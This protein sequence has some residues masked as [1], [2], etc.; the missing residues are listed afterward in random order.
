MS[1]EQ[2][3][4]AYSILNNSHA[5]EWT[6][7]GFGMIRTY[8]DTDKR[9]R[10][11]VW[12]DRLRVP[13]VTTIHDHPWGFASTIICGELHNQIYSVWHDYPPSHEFT[14]IMTGED[15][16][17]LRT[18]EQNQVYLWPSAREIKSKG[19]RYSQRLDT[20]HETFYKRGT[21]TLNDRT[22]PT[23]EHSARVFYPIGT[24]WIDAK[25][26]LATAEEVHAAVLAAME[27]L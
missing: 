3:A 8:L 23:K 9:W 11:N 7:Q 12:D 10:L 15:G 2:K 22:Q 20:I 16:G 14:E 26:R 24:K 5:Y 21:V 17:A 19:D 13:G 27:L 18:P 4:I 25:P 1:S 6:M